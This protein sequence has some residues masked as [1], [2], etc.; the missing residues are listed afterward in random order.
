MLLDLNFEINE[1]LKLILNSIRELLD[2]QWST[3]KLRAFME[4]DQNLAN[5]LWKEII[6]LE[7]LPYFSSLQLKDVI[8]INELI[9]SRLLPGIVVSSMIASRGIKNKDILSKLYSGEIKLAI[10]DSEMVP[11]AD[12]ADLILINNKLVQ[13]KNCNLSI[14]NSIDNSM[15]ISKVE[16]SRY[17]NNIEVNNAEIALLLASQMLGSGEEVLNMSVRY[18]KER[19]A[20]GK[21]IGSYQAIKHRVVNDAID[22]E[23]VRS[24][25]LEASENIKY[26]WLAK[27]IANKKIPKVILSAIQV[28]GGIGFTDDLDIH[29]HL[30]RALTLSKMYN[31]K[32]NIS[33]FLQAI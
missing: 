20:F 9:G 5:Q 1:D 23:L 28:H 3:K 30:R 18:S 11:A 27:D 10:S 19:V 6:K 15:R 29:L 8:I 14:F 7:I 12:Q 21:P 13:R 31:S 4:G 17:E 22:V 32:I 2:S 33:E 26:T 16:C 24:I 25:I